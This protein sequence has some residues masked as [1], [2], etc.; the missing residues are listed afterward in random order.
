MAGAT[1]KAR[2]GSRLVGGAIA[3]VGALLLCWLLLRSGRDAPGNEVAASGANSSEMPNALR[4]PGAAAREIPSGTAGDSR[5]TG[6]APPRLPG[7][8]AAAVPTAQNPSPAFASGGPASP[9][10]EF[11]A[12]ASTSND[13]KADEPKFP[14]DWGRCFRTYGDRDA[15]VF[16]S[17]SSTAS[18]G[19]WSAR[20]SSR[21]ARPNPS[22]AALCQTLSAAEF[23]GRR[24]RITLH[25]RTQDA[26]PAA[27]MVFRAAGA[28]G[29]VL[30]FYNMEPHWVGGSTS[31]AEYS[32][33]LD[34]PAEAA[35]IMFGGSLVNTGSVWLDDA[36]IEV[37]AS[38]F[39]VTHVS[40]PR[41]GY[42]A[43]VDPSGLAKT[44]NNPGFEETRALRQGE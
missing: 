36:S 4:P 25:M 17:D 37:V 6:H 14:R 19:S 34:L 32:A 20:I 8:S 40:P 15:Y 38:D 2:S 3:V 18:S 1:R 35:T 23:A 27:H 22:G 30:T 10:G 7:S 13:G 26:M 9:V 12:P 21:V 44:L 11:A 28:D 39:P 29:R 33:V 42:I 24:L 41:G 43:V 5:V 31:W 16:A